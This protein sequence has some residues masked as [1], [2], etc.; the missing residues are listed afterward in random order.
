MHIRTFNSRIRDLAGTM[1][2]PLEE[3]EIKMKPMYHVDFKQWSGWVTYDG[4]TVY[5]MLNAPRQGRHLVRMADGPTDYTGGYN[6]FF[7]D[8]S[9]VHAVMHG[10]ISGE[11]GLVSCEK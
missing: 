1:D 8:D 2:I 7:D 9:V 10:L 6:H 5:V 11:S 3:L 4:D